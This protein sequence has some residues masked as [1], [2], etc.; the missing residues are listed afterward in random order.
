MFYDAT[1]LDCN[2][3]SNALFRFN[4]V[5]N[6]TEMIVING[7][8][9]TPVLERFSFEGTTANLENTAYVENYIYTKLS[10]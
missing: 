6:K 3:Y 1:L 10:I 7:L 8:E 4:N 5:T 9:D 2:G